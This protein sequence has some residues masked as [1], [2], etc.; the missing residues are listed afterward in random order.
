VGCV[1]SPPISNVIVLMVSSTQRSRSQ[2][3]VHFQRRARHAKSYARIRLTWPAC[4]WHN[5]V[6]YGHGVFSQTSYP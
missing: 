3:R 4:G 6:H 2:A 5:A 1:D